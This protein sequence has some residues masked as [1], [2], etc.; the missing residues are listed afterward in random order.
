MTRAGRSIYFACAVVHMTACGASVTTQSPVEQASSVRTREEAADDAVQV[1]GLRGTL[2]EHEIQKALDPRLPKF[3][4]CMGQRVEDVEWLSG[5]I[6]LSFHVAL[7]GSVGSA[8][9]RVST[10]GDR[11]TEQC[12]VGVASATRFPRPHGGEADFDWPLEIPISDDVRAPVELAGDAL[13]QVEA[14]VAGAVA[15]RC[16][17]GRFQVTMYIGTDGSVVAAGAAVDDAALSSQL[18]CVAEAA[19]SVTLESP[20]SYAAKVSFWTE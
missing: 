18:D 16:G 3:A 12:L 14:L 9:P 15:E 11:Q 10:L 8:H 1:T 13:A 17:G 7:D 5:A 19:A 2:S 4:R 20:G 6:K